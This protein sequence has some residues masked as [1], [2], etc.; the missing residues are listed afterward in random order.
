RHRLRPETVRTKYLS[1]VAVFRS[2][3]PLSAGAGEARGIRERQRAGWSPPSHARRFQIRDAGPL[4]GGSGRP[5][6]CRVADAAGEGDGDGRVVG[7]GLRPTFA[8][9][10]LWRALRS[11]SMAHP[12]LMR[13]MPRHRAHQ[14]RPLANGRSARRHASMPP[15][16]TYTRVKPALTSRRAAFSDSVPLRDTTAIGNSRAFFSSLFS[17]S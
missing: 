10:H 11:P 5:A 3:A 15:E 1:D 2:H 13:A 8:S 7:A 14:P 4:V 6:R 16:S 9:S 17:G 12:R